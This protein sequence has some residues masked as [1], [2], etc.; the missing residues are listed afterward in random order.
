[1][2]SFEK[3]WEL[4]K[5]LRKLSTSDKLEWEKSIN[6]GVYQVSFPQYTVCI[7]KRDGNDEADDYYLQITNEDGEIVEE[8]ND[9]VLL[10]SLPKLGSEVYKTFAALFS[11]ARSRALGVDAALLSLSKSLDAMDDSKGVDL[12]TFEE[13]P[14]RGESESRPGGKGQPD[15]FGTGITDDDVP[16]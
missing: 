16:F 15:P 3:V 6:A 1:M 11:M 9:V 2:T 14:K 13:L 7:Y 10:Q 12:P 4:L 5:K 8:T